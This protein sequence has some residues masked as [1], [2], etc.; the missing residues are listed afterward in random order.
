ML[1]PAGKQEAVR[2]LADDAASTSA[3][4]ALAAFDESFLPVN[5]EFKTICHRWQL[6]SDDQPNDHSD[7]AYDAEVVEQ[8]G[9]F[10]QRF[11]PMLASVTAALPR[12]DRY[13]TRLTAALSRIEGGDSA[14]FARPMYDSYH[15]IWMELHNDV[16]LT[17]G[18]QRGA[19]DEQVH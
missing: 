9:R 18:R 11:L 12:F 1:T 14:A 6:K 5:A 15:D 3:Q 16:V 19:G 7:P 17:L 4:G 2:R 13:P 8:L 10:H